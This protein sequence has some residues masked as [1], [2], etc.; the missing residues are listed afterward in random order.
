MIISVSFN[1]H[2]RGDFGGTVCAARGNALRIWL[3]LLY[4]RVADRSDDFHILQHSR[5]SRPFI[6]LL[7]IGA[8]ARVFDFLADINYP[9]YAT[10]ELLESSGCG[11]RSGC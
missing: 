5:C 1:Y 9:L 11:S 10:M 8:V 2:H 4:R 3:Q 7:Q 6:Y